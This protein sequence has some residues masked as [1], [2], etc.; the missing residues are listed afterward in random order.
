MTPPGRAL[1]GPRAGRAAG[2][3][4]GQEG[5]AGP[6]SPL[7]GLGTVGGLGGTGTIEIAALSAVTQT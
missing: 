4:T 3:L 2:P 6:W 5:G 7:T 1:R